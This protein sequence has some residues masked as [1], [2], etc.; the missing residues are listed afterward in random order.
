[1]KDLIYHYEARGMISA[2]ESCIP[3]IDVGCLDVHQVR[4]ELNID[5]SYFLV[6]CCC[7]TPMVIA[8]RIDLSAYVP[9]A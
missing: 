9:T 3:H 1:M 2:I 8:L 7:C 5:V 6:H 4:I